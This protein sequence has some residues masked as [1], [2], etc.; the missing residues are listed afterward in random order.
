[1]SYVRPRQSWT[2]AQSA[3]ESVVSREPSGE[4]GKKISLSKSFPRNSSKSN[5]F[6]ESKPSDKSESIQLGTVSKSFYKESL[7]SVGAKKKG[8][9][10]LEI[11]RSCTKL[12]A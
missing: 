9:K 8:K 12:S 1:M 5:T 7:V 6:S 4:K 10:F 11:T 3:A 2:G